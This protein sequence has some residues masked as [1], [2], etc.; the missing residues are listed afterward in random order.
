[1]LKVK[2]VFVQSMLY[3]CYPGYLSLNMLNDKDKKKNTVLIHVM[4]INGIEENRRVQRFCYTIYLLIPILT[5]VH[6]KLQLPTQSVLTLFHF[7]FLTGDRKSV[8]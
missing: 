4:V 1:M 3:A 8:V 2:H 6:V 7:L 5:A